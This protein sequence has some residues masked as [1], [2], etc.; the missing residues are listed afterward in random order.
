MKP[1]I[2]IRPSVESDGPILGSWIIKPDVLRWFPMCD[3]REIDDSVRIWMGYSRLGASF[4]AEYDG[5]PA[6]MAVL[7][8]QPYQRFSH[9]ALF[10]II[11]NEDFRNRGIGKALIEYFERV[12]REQFKIT[13][14]HL[15]VYDG[16]PAKRLYEREGYK[17]YG[18]HP[19]FIKEA[20]K[21]IC[22][23]LMQKDITHGRT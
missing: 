1:L 18:R 23:I 6:G 21:Y 8:L 15:E 20:G 16:N 13:L 19:R 4:T 17:E 5:K 7:Y 12:A 2:V 9:H 11:V 22:K 3:Q 14:L 10:A